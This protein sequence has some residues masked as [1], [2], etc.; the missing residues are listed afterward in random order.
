MVSLAFENKTKTEE[1]EALV[2]IK[3]MVCLIMY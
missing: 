1:R 2:Q 3:S